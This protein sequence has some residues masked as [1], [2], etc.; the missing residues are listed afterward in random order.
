M[1]HQLEPV[2]AVFWYAPEVFAEAARLGYNTQ[3]R[4]PSYFAWR[5]APLGAVGPRLAAAAC[6]SF[7]PDM[8]AAHVP[9][10]WAVA[11]PERVLATREHAVDRMYRALLGD[12]IGSPG[13]AEAAHLARD[14]ALS[15][16]TAGRPLAA[17][18]ADLPWAGEPHLV[19]WHAINV[20]REQRGDAHIAAL[21]AAGLDPCE[22][23]VSF[24]AIGAAPQEVF[25]SRGWSAADWATA[26]DR[27]AARGW[28]DAAGK[29]TQRGRDVRD[30]VEWRTDRLAEGP[31]QALGPDRSARLSELTAPLL[32]AAFE[33]GLL[34]AQS[35]LGI[36]TVPA[37]SP[38]PEIRWQLARR[39]QI[40]QAP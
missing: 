35:T 1:W 18:N 28:I 25:A 6:F 13:L 4:W 3:T 2:H 17:A 23:L 26:R 31:W 19:L 22:A 14:A 10:A 24:A 39:R 34:P 27:L 38:R 12:L 32:G 11:A 40:A 20:L 30:E 37:P 16:G 33:A 8:V 5:L 7:S 15:A 21:Q 9:A 36:A 29:A